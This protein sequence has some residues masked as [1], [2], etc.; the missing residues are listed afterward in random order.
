MLIE[1][2]VRGEVMTR[3]EVPDE[4]LELPGASWERA[5]QYREEVIR[6]FLI[7][8]RDKMN[9]FIK[10]GIP[11]EYRLVFRSK[12]NLIDDE[13]EDTDTSHGNSSLRTDVGHAPGDTADA[14]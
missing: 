7:K 3:A 4:D 11:I 8:L 2:I 12:L 6:L 5:A 1:A 9:G 10:S 13:T 14:G